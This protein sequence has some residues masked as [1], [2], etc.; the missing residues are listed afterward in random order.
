M[1]TS[2]DPDHWSDDELA[3]W[4]RRAMSELHDAPA[5]LVASA[6]ALWRAP[7]PSALQQAAAPSAL[8]QVLAALRFD[9]WAAGPSFALR[10]AAVSSRHLL[11]AA[12]GRDIDLR[13][14]AG[15]PPL[16]DLTGQVLGPGDTGEV[17]LEAVDAPEPGSPP[18]RTVLDEL[19]GFELTGLPG[20]R[21]RMRLQLDADSIELPLLDLGD[22]P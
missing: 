5:W 12:G 16:F 11:F 4:G 22:R 9:S 10:S 21:Y 19:G 7:A 20:G 6:V 14:S 1:T 18:R 8:Q 3:R 13:I 15:V 17:V 2:T